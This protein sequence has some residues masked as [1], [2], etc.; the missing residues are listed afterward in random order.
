ME[1]RPGFAFGLSET[2]TNERRGQ[3]DVHKAGIPWDRHGHLLRHQ[4]G[5]PRRLPRENRREDVGVSADFVLQA[6]VTHDDPRRLVRRLVRRARF[7][8]RGFPLGMRACTRVNVYCT[9]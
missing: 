7:S 5:H 6:P 2:L 3:K 1:R 8:L 9:R 4:H